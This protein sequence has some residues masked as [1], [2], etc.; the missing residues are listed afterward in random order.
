M[1]I[2]EL[3]CFQSL[4]LKQHDNESTNTLNRN[5]KVFKRWWV[6]T[7]RI[8][9]WSRGSLAFFSLSSLVIL[10][11]AIGELV[12]TSS[13]ERYGSIGLS[14]MSILINM[15]VFAGM[16]YFF[17]QGADNFLSKRGDLVDNGSEETDSWLPSCVR[18]LMLKVMGSSQDARAFSPERLKNS[19]EWQGRVHH[20]QSKIDQLAHDTFE[21]SLRQAQDLEQ[22][23][24][25]TEA[26]LKSEMVALD[27]RVESLSTCLLFEIRQLHESTLSRLQSGSTLRRSGDHED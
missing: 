6:S 1:L 8:D 9:G 14:L 11:W 12:G 10:L 13:G 3:V 7:S 25:N 20:I 22:L 23:V 5:S 2:S 18:N 26:R 4:L 17:S 16:M 27:Q 24:A 21:H 15:M 19:N